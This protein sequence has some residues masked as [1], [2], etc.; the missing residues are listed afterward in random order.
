VLPPPP[1]GSGTPA[2]RPAAAEAVIEAAPSEPAATEPVELLRSAKFVLAGSDERLDVSC[3][4]VKAGGSGNALLNNF[5]AGTCTVRVGA[6]TTSVS[7]QEPRK[8]EC[9]LVEGTLSCR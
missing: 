2:R 8:V 6:A 1:G 5:P 3:G 7:V 4:T 9:T